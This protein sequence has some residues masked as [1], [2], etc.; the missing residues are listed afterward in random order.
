MHAP[1]TTACRA[2]FVHRMKSTQAGCVPF[3]ATNRINPSPIRCK[4][5]GD[6]AERDERLTAQ[7][8]HG[9]TPPIAPGNRLRQARAPG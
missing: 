1:I 2:K 8:A 4:E 7:P 9:W 5:A 6:A 3:P